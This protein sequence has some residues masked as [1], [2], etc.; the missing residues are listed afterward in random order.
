MKQTIAQKQ[1]HQPDLPSNDESSI[2]AIAY[3]NM[4]LE[5]EF[6]NDFEGAIFSYSEA[7]RIAE[8]AWGSAHVKTIA[9]EQ[10]LLR[11]SK[12]Q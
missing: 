6:L 11:A 7:H 10:S 8:C 5:Q 1:I 12:A 9:M 2:L 3:H 4:A